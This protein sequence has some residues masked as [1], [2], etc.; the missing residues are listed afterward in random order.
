MFKAFILELKKKESNIFDLASEI[1][2]F[3]NDD[4]T[5]NEMTSLIGQVKS[6]KYELDKSQVQYNNME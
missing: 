4:N 3:N 1:N 6:K 2:C 5:F